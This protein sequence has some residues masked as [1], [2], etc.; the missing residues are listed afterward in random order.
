M[1][2]FLSGLGVVALLLCGSLAF[3]D[4]SVLLKWSAPTERENGE[5]L[6][7][8]DLGGYEIRYLLQGAD[9]SETKAVVVPDGSATSYV[10]AD[11]PMGDHAFEIA[12][13]DANGLY[14]NF[15]GIAYAQPSRP[16]SIGNVSASVPVNDV[17]A[18]CLADP[19]CKVAVAGEW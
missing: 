19:S 10:F 13:Y 5:P 8:A 6:T 14:S 18:A 1:K 9:E 12:V 15:I 17:I 7:T 3:A 11:L 4:Q 2:K 16:G